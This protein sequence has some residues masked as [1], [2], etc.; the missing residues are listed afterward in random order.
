MK[1]RFLKLTALALLSTAIITAE[2]CRKEE[3]A[4]ETIDNGGSSNNGGSGNNNN[5]GSGNNGG[6][7]NGGSGN[8]GGNTIQGCTDSDS[9]LF[10]TNA[11]SDDGSCQY[12]YTSS[13]QI[14]YY[15]ADDNGSNWDYGFGSTANAD[16]V[17][18][19][20]EQGASSYIFESSEASNQDPST[21]AQWSAPNPI[22]LLNKT[23]VWELIDVDSG[24][25]D[26]PI[27]NGT[28]NPITSAN[29]STHKITTTA[30]GSEL[31]ITFT[32]Q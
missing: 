17:L 15:P 28:F 21:P 24:N 11:T 12:A 9:P 19:I 7:N 23:Y 14:T 13:Y 26:D 16:L 1:N 2:S 27:S 3:P 31:V 10:N 20:K 18:K 29:T 32:L 6:G 4:P 30:G 8:G 22:K 25:P 5:G